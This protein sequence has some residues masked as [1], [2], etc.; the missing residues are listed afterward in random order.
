MCNKILQQLSFQIVSMQKNVYW[1][2]IDQ[3]KSSGTTVYNL[4]LNKHCLQ[5]NILTILRAL[6]LIDYLLVFDYFTRD[7]ITN[8]VVIGLHLIKGDST[9]CFRDISS[10]SELWAGYSCGHLWREWIIVLQYKLRS[11]SVLDKRMGNLKLIL[12]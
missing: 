9:K 10:C 1:L 5:P 7:G 11:G 4:L 2:W 3:F 12:Y 8:H 6:V